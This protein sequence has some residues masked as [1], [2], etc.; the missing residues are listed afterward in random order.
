[1]MQ[2]EIGMPVLP[3]NRLGDKPKKNPEEKKTKKGI[4]APQPSK[5]RTGTRLVGRTPANKRLKRNS[6]N[7]R[8]S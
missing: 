7:P 6:R 1:M 3:K 8:R 2:S 4:V 5:T